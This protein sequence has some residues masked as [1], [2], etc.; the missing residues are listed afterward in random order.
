MEP[1][2]NTTAQPMP[3][4]RSRGHLPTCIVAAGVV[5]ASLSW[6]CRRQYLED[7]EF[8]PG[9]HGFA[10]IIEM[11]W[12][13]PSAGAVLVV[14][15]L[16]HAVR[17]KKL[18]YRDRKAT[19]IATG[20]ILLMVVAA[21]PLMPSLFLAG[22]REAYAR[23][24]VI[25]LSVACKTLVNETWAADDRKEPLH[26]REWHEDVLR[27]PEAI[28]NLKPLFVTIAKNGV[29]IQMDGGGPAMHEGMWLPND[30]LAGEVRSY[31]KKHGVRVLSTNPP[32]FA[33][34]LYDS[35]MLPM[36]P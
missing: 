11:M 16:V 29:V 15:W 10:F 4:R 36:T 24:N 5:A 1:S 35:R 20:M 19:W 25:P 12:L 34:N 7:L 27:L 2:R 3:E 26:I 6:A 33:Y 14:L 13:T 18:V 31:A 21:L 23:V 22:R 8:V 32:V 17:R 28:R 30:V 9:L